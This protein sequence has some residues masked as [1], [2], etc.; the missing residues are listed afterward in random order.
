MPSG[1][2]STGAVHASPPMRQ[3]ASPTARF[4]GSMP[5]AV[6]SS[7]FFAVIRSAASRALRSA[8]SSRKRLDR[9]VERPVMNCGRLPGWA[10]V[11][12]MPPP[13]AVVEV[14]E[15]RGAAQFG[16][17]RPQPVSLGLGD[18][19][20]GHSRFRQTEIARGHGRRV[21]LCADHGAAFCSPHTATLSG[22]GPVPRIALP[23]FAGLGDT[24]ADQDPSSPDGVGTRSSPGSTGAARC[25]S[26][27][28]A[29]M[30]A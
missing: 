26:A 24:P 27:R 13:F 17:E 1:R 21:V 30:V 14:Q 5:R 20:H 22:A 18:V 11:I 15:R 8:T 29:R 23:S 7:T 16:R 25:R 9:S 6:R 12:S 19:H 3:E 10:L 28:R 2:S 4:T